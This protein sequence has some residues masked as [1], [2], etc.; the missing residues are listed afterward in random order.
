MDG[1]IIIAKKV[2]EYKSYACTSHKCECVAVP[3]DAD[4]QTHQPTRILVVCVQGVHGFS[5]KMEDYKK[6][7][8]V[9]T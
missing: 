8:A 9:S 1:R 3:V 6:S 7:L 4:P 2:T 5:I